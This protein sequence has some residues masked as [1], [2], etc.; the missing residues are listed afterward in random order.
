MVSSGSQSPVGAASSSAPHRFAGASFPDRWILV[1][2]LALLGATL[3]VRLAVALA[4]YRS[5]IGL[6]IYQDDAFYYLK[7]A[8]NIV[9]GR[10]VTFDGVTPTNGFHPL[11]LILLLP[12][13]AASGTDLIAPIRASAILL[14][15]VAVITG[16]LVFRLTRRLA[17]PAAALIA[18]AVWALSPYFTVLG[19]NGL[20][21][22]LAMLFAVASLYAYLEWV[23][24]AG[25]APSRRRAAALGAVFGLAAL[26]RIDLLLLLAAIGLDWLAIA[27][28]LGRPRPALGRIAVTAAL[29]LAVWLPWGIFSRVETGE[30]LPASGSATRQIALAYGWVGLPLVWAA[31]LRRPGADPYFDPDRVP[32]AYFADAATQQLS[33]FLLEHPLLAALRVHLPYSVWPKLWRYPPHAAFRRSP[34][35]AA[36]L[37]ALLFAGAVAGVRRASARPAAAIGGL[38]GVYL[39]LTFLAYTFYCPAYW[40]YSRYL[41]PAVL[42]TLIFGV[43]ALHGMLLPFWRRGGGARA[44]VLAG[45]L[46]LIGGQIAITP[47]STLARVRWS[48]AEP[49][50]FLRGWRSLESRIDPSA[51]LG[52]F[53]AGVFSWFGQRDVVNLDGKMN[54]D[55]AR[56]LARRELGAYIESRKIDYILDW[57]GI[58][59][60]LCTRHL[61]TGS[62]GFREIARE[63]PGGLGFVLWAV[64]RPSP[65]LPPR[66]D[67][68][69]RER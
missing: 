47:D 30:W 24:L 27:I 9:R 15:A 25:G 2:L 35:N 11:Y 46:L 19:I 26:A 50:G 69:A 58:L 53:Q 28:R 65:A 32:A 12:I 56:A 18:L 14:S 38:V 31:E 43:S 45:I 60:S 22:G 10:G 36:A 62:P 42:V 8:E 37:A 59:H 64:E 41:T 54:P 6:D 67:R 5:L 21:T 13:M 29:A 23:R 34:W 57:P 20:E 48:D 68:A 1:G 49:G 4:D 66:G 55:A 51:T 39:L 3:A 52:A 7:L 17:G 16:W 40:Y 63:P 61:R 33:V 44:A